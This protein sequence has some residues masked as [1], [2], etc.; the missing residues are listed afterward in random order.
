MKK[1]NEKI[2]FDFN[3]HID[4]DVE[5]VDEINKHCK[6]TKVLHFVS[7]FDNH[8]IGIIQKEIEKQ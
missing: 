8:T 7:T 5:E 4:D 3:F 1:L 6:G 2:A